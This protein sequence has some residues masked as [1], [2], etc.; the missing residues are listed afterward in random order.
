V[1]VCRAGKSGLMSKVGKSGKGQ[2]RC[3]NNA[4]LWMSFMDS[5]LII[6]SKLAVTFPGIHMSNVSSIK[7]RAMY[8]IKRLKK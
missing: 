7:H 4:L 6:L 5:P 8:Y 1:N 2:G 3:K